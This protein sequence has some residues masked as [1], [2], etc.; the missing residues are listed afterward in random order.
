[1]TSHCFILDRA[2]PPRPMIADLIMVP[3][4]EVILRPIKPSPCRRG[5]RPNRSA[6][7]PCDAPL[8]ARDA[9]RTGRWELVFHV[10]EYFTGAGVALPDSPFLD[11][12]SI[13]R[14]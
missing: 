7:V 8:L 3:T 6:P 9:F 11:Q 2:V 12:V 5:R 13:R 1:M 10:G 14:R 4:I